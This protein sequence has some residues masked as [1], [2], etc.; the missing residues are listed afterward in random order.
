MLLPL[1]SYH[2]P[3]LPLPSFQASEMNIPGLPCSVARLQQAINAVT[4]P[5]TPAVYLHG[6]N[7]ASL[8]TF[9]PERPQALRGCLLS[10]ADLR[11]A[12]VVIESGE[13]TQPAF[14]GAYDT[15]HRSVSTYRYQSDWDKYVL[16][17]LGQYCGY[18][19]TAGRYPLVYV[20]EENGQFQKMGTEW[21]SPRVHP[22]H[23]LGILV[24][25]EHLDDATARV[26][27]SGLNVRVA[28]LSD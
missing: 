20:I 28:A 24:P 7:S 12:G 18:N 16:D 11:E 2:S 4:L 13:Q 14:T 9:S 6:S 17:D 8:S 27:A 3:T 25:G 21:Q 1:P 19:T 22:E 23:L 10:L 26:A 5:G 15:A